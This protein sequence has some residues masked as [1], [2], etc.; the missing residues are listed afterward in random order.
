[1]ANDPNHA[2][3]RESEGKTPK[4]TKLWSVLRRAA[5]QAG[6]VSGETIRKGVEVSGQMARTVGETAQD[7]VGKVQRRLGEDY[8]TILAENPIVERTMSQ[9]D[10]LAVDSTLLST[11]FNIPWVTTL[12]WS[13]AAGSTVALSGS[14]AGVVQQILHEGPG[15]I[16]RWDEINKFMDGWVKAGDGYARITDSAGKAIAGVGHR[17]KWGHSLEALP[18]IVEKFGVEGVPAFLTHLLQ[19]F[20]STD[21]VPVVPRAWDIKKHLESAGLAKEAATGLVSISFSSMLGAMAVITLVTRLW[22]F[23]DAMVKKARVRNYLRTAGAATQGRD[24]NAAIANYQR[25]LEIERGPA[26]LMALGQVYTRRASTRLRAHQAFTEAVTLLADRP[27]STVPYGH[28]QLSLRGLAGLHALSTADVLANIHPEHW[29]DY[30]QDLVNA[31]VFSF[32]S[33]AAKQDQQKD[34]LVPDALVTP[35]HLSAAINHY[36]AAKT[37]CYY[38]L[39]EDRQD[40]VVRNLRAALRSIGLMAQYDEQQL[41]QPANTLSKLWSWELLQPD[42]IQTELATYL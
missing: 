9:A 22:Q 12:L 11:A 19:D 17:L 23:G 36:L 32:I 4:Q 10:L 41:R 20:T 39:A 33:A 15:H 6:Q 37:A 13:A 28:A 8:Y 18:E 25:A 14:I 26:A 40:I 38:P 7:T 34:D 30:V 21:G 3:Q 35:A 2:G 27:A 5:D 1:M 42:Q 29:N 24:Y 31:S 16:H